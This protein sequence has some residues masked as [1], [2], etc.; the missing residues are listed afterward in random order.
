M[1][2][3]AIKGCCDVHNIELNET[4][5]M[6]LL[7]LPVWMTLSRA[8]CNHVSL[9]V[10]WMKLK[11]VPIYLALDEVE[12]QIETCEQFRK[13]SKSKP[14]QPSY[15]SV[16]TLSYVFSNSF[17]FIHSVIPENMVSPIGSSMG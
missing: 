9:K 16:C 12:V 5:L 3:S 7:E 6:D 1:N 17:F 11:T 2:L 14:N 4:V 13:D 15:A 10:Q 8:V